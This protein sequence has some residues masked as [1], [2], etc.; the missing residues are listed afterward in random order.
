MTRSRARKGKNART[1]SNISKSLV[2]GTICVV[3][4]VSHIVINNVGG[5]GAGGETPLH[6]NYGVL[7]I[8]G[9]QD[10]TYNMGGI[11]YGISSTAGLL[12][13]FSVLK[14]KL[15]LRLRNG[16]AIGILFSIIP[17]SNSLHGQLG[18]NYLKRLDALPQCKKLYLSKAGVTGDTKTM[19]VTYD[20]PKI[21]GFSKDQYLGIPDYYGASSGIG[22]S[23]TGYYIQI[24]TDNLSTVLANG[25]NIMVEADY[26]VKAIQ[27]NTKLQL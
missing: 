8:A 25:V 13:N 23:Y 18:A 16:D 4:S 10:S 17:I 6:P 21:E 22:A 1:S 9:S 2:D 12:V 11:F 27:S 5:I 26:T 20:C 14:A 19:K 24:L 3:R 7:G 15:T